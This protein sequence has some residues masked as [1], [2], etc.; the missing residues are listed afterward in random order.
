MKTD[1]AF[2]SFKKT[3]LAWVATVNGTYKEREDAWSDYWKARDAFFN[4]R[5]QTQG[6]RAWALA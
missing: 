3:Y 1:E 4:S 2:E 6:I 5:G